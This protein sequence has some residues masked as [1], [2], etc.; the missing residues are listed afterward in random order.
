[1]V[2]TDN[3]YQQPQFIVR[4]RRQQPT[5]LLRCAQA[6][7]VVYNR[8]LC[9]KSSN[10]RVIICSACLHTRHAVMKGCM[11]YSQGP[12]KSDAYAAHRTRY[13]LEAH[14]PSSAHEQRA[15][16]R[17]SFLM[18]QRRLL[19]YDAPYVRRVYTSAQAVE[20][21]K[22]AVSD[23]II[24]PAAHVKTKWKLTPIRK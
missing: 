4:R 1:M 16:P 21:Q 6:A 23:H 20:Q 24:S 14:L 17:C 9:F 12:I 15:P 5:I 2:H 18:Y 19:H 8:R 7:D 11:V 22:S 10:Q 3:T 13:L